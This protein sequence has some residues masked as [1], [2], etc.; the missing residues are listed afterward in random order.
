MPVRIVNLDNVKGNEIVGRSIYDNTGRILLAEGIRLTSWYVQKLKSIG[1]LSVYIDDQISKDVIIEENVS[2]NTRQLSKRAINDIMNR[3]YKYGKVGNEGIVKSVNSIIDEILSTKEIM[4]NISEIRT[5]D[6]E[7]CSH[8]VNVC[9]LAT[10][11]GIHLGYNMLKLKELATGAILHDIGKSRILSDKKLVKEKNEE[12]DL[13]GY[14]KKMH[15]KVGYDFL[16]QQ[17]ICTAVSK[18]IALMHHEKIDGSGYPFGLRDNEI[19]ESAMLVSVCNLFDNMISGH[20]GFE[21]MPVYQVLEFVVSMGGYY[22]NKNIVNTFI[23]HIAAF[24]SGS[25]VILNTQ[26]RGLVIR[27]N[28]SFPLRP[29]V[30]VIYGRN[31]EKIAE[32]Y[33]IDLLKELTVFIIQTCDIET[34]CEDEYYD[35]RYSFRKD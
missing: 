4:I 9:V 1:I 5:K 26:E 11:I 20:D 32:P 12:G 35:E 30:K 3:Y 10:L 6:D 28:K 16:S 23:M 33:E 27:Q 15:P 34:I 18:V 13:E 21:K 29:V 17:N 14:V 24:P 25:A 2:D 8:S 19:H 31:N 7:I 22:F